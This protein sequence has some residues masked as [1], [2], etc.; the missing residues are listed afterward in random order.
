MVNTVNYFFSA[1]EA[2]LGSTE[3]IVAARPNLVQRSTLQHG[4]AFLMLSRLVASI[5]TRSICLFTAGMLSSKYSFFSCC[6]CL[7][8]VKING[9]KKPLTL[10]EHAKAGLRR[11]TLSHV[12]VLVALPQDQT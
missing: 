7:G 10:R 8:V 2:T 4:T 5:V 11:D 3:T 6:R 1:A 9:N 12:V